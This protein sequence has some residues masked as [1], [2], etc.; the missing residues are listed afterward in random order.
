MGVVILYRE[1]RTWKVGIR[2]RMGE[3]MILV[4]IGRSGGNS[5]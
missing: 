4:G 3:A 5:I 1:R 2:I